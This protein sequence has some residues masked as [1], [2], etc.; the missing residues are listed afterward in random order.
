MLSAV[1]QVEEDFEAAPE[2]Q[3]VEP[4]EVGLA[5]G[6]GD[7]EAVEVVVGLE[8]GLVVVED[9][10]GSEGR[11]LAACKNLSSYCNSFAVYLF[12]NLT[13][14]GGTE[15]SNLTFLQ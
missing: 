9:V 13:R 1:R 5:G 3:V 6:A 14:Y 15:K 7:L 12:P 8:V 4:L 2:A 11:S 10:G